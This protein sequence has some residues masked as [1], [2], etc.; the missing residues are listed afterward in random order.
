MPPGSEWLNVICVCKSTVSCHEAKTA[1]K[2]AQSIYHLLDCATVFRFVL[3]PHMFSPFLSLSKS[4]MQQGCFI[5]R[6]WKVF[7]KSGLEPSSVKAQLKAPGPIFIRV[8]W[9]LGCWIYS[10]QFRGKNTQSITMYNKT[11]P[12]MIFKET[13]KKTFLRF[14][15]LLCSSL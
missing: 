3:L 15:A 12:E 10:A 1:L 14:S 7:K 9:K 4:L 2:K 8:K 13:Q 5:S 6:R 11:C